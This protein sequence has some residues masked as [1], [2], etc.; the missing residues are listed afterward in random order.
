M[1]KIIDF[2]FDF[3]SPYAY[4]GYKEIKKLE[5]K[6]SFKIKFMPVFLGGLHNSAGITPAAFINLK[7]K[8][9]IDDTRL[10][11]KKKIFLFTLI[12]IFQLK[13]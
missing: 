11:S 7:S 9:M 8:Y 6:N 5:K 1:N 2:Y 10:V 4:I 12:H 3:S 13:L